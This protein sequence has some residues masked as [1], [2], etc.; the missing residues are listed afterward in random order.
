MTVHSITNGLPRRR[1]I[2]RGGVLWR[3]CLDLLVTCFCTPLTLFMKPEIGLPPPFLAFYW[4]TITLRVGLNP[5]LV[6][7]T[8]HGDRRPKRVHIRYRL[9][10]PYSRQDL[11]CGAIR[12]MKI[13][14]HDERP[15]ALEFLLEGILNHGYKAGIARDGLEIINMLADE[16]YNEKWSNGEGSA[17]SQG[18]HVG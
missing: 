10:Q 11:H 2:L 9:P 5:L 8:L 1:A 14:I 13:V 17:R 18:C 15:D 6:G 4:K 16:R 12:N 7:S 3:N